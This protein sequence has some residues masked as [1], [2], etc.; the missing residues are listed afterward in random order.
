MR[1]T[2]ITL[3]LAAGCF[4]DHPTASDL[5]QSDCIS[6]HQ[7]DFAQSTQHKG[8]GSTAC[9]ACHDPNTMP[10]WAFAHPQAPFPTETGRH[11]QFAQQCH[12]CHDAALGNDYIANL[13]CY[14]GGA[15]HANSHHHDP[16][17]PGRCFQCHPTGNAGGGD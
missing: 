11:A 6:C 2:I 13:D 7:T 5:A 3:L 10:P 12:T 9:A 1:I 4:R 15:C 16:T 8:Q 17:Q 14:G